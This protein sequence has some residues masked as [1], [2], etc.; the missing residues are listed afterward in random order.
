MF[1]NVRHA[2]QRLI[3]YGHLYTFLYA[4]L[5]GLGV[6]SAE[7]H[8]LEAGEPLPASKIQDMEHGFVCGIFRASRCR[9]LPHSCLRH[10][11]DETRSRS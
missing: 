5:L 10:V 3:A 7:K 11:D 9:F 2:A 4:F 8:V 1:G 6:C